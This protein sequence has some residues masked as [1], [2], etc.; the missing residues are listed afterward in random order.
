MLQNLKKN[1]WEFA[2]HQTWMYWRL[3]AYLI[4]LALISQLYWNF[5]I[6]FLAFSI[7]YIL[8]TAK[9]IRGVCPICAVS[10]F[11]LSLFSSTSLREA[12]SHLFQSSDGFSSKS[13]PFLKFEFFHSQFIQCFFFAFLPDGWI[14]IRSSSHRNLAE[15][16]NFSLHHFMQENICNYS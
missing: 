16:H 1:H 7:F 9:V 5:A 13:S 14:L 11:L 15:R 6:L 8:I 4:F 2:R 12:A 3:S 10:E